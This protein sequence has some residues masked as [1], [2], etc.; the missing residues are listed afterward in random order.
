M[1]GSFQSSPILMPGLTTA[2]APA[3][4]LRARHL[5]STK[6]ARWSS[7]PWFTDEETGAQRGSVTCPKSHSWQVA[8]LG[9]ASCTWK[10][11]HPSP[12]RP[13][14]AC[15]LR[16]QVPVEVAP[17][18]PGLSGM[19]QMQGN[20]QRGPAPD[21]VTPGRSRFPL[22]GAMS[23]AEKRAGGHFP[24]YSS[25]KLQVPEIAWAFFYL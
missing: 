10:E 16:S 15:I 6:P 7:H 9:F 19:G 11:P 3:P 22:S 21:P 23:R 2:A 24:G 1:W 20:E 14:L 25:R 17:G 18:T 5:T 13:N 8:E 12:Q 4:T